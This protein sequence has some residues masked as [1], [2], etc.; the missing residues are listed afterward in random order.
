MGKRDEQ[1]DIEAMNNWINMNEETQEVFNR[2]VYDFP[3]LMMT[4]R[5]RIQEEGINKYKEM[6]DNEVEKACRDA[7]ERSRKA[8]EKENVISLWDGRKERD[9][10]IMIKAFAELSTDDRQRVL[11]FKTFLDK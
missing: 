2:Y 7:D 11:G 5:K 6:T 8:E 3:F 9:T 4:I 10:I 1:R